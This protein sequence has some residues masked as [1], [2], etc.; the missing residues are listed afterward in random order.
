MKL[1]SSAEKR[2]LHAYLRS[3]VSLGA[4]DLHLKVG[5]PPTLRI[6]GTLFCMDESSCSTADLEE[7]T[8]IVLTPQQ[9][10]EIA[11]AL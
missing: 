11:D 9:R 1:E 8:S 6:D 10:K 4:S 2:D 7:L 3:M 5:A